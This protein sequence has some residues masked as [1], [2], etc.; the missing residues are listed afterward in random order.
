MYDGK[1][2]PIGANTPLLQPQQLFADGVNYINTAQ[3]PF[4]YTVFSTLCKGKDNSSVA[5]LYN[6][7]LCHFFVKEYT[8][9]IAALNEGLIQISAPSTS[10]QFTAS[11]PIE[12]LNHEYAHNFYRFALTEIGVELNHNLIKLRI[13]RLLVDVQLKLKNWQ[14]IIGLSALPDMEKCKNVQEALTIS[15][16]NT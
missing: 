3:W 4:A 11:L 14:E 1:A 7:A 6:M 9:A 15:K 8:K 13:R 5:I 10:H 12:A 2:K 16:S